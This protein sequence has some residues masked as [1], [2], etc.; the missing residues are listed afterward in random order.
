MRYFGKIDKYQVPHSDHPYTEK[1]F[2]KKTVIKNRKTKKVGS[3]IFV[4]NSLL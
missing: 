3:K 2:R 1:L 4:I